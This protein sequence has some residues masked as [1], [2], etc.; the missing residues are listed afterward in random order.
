MVLHDGICIS[1][2]YELMQ[3]WSMWNNEKEPVDEKRWHSQDRE[4][5]AL[6]FSRR[7]F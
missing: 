6:V 5:G 1:S 7:T 3:G 2:R 4:R